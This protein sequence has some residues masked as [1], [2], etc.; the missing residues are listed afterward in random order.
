VG[1]LDDKGPGHPH[2]H[3]QD[4]TKGTT[5][6]PIQRGDSDSPS[7]LACLRL[8]TD[9]PNAGKHRASLLATLL[10]IAFGAPGVIIV[11]ARS[12]HHCAVRT[13]QANPPSKQ[14]SKQAS[15]AGGL[16]AVESFT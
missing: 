2:T 12:S 7:L 14:A 6:G 4:R 16:S 3:R 8:R 10:P 9:E 11:D 13:A 15:N 1:V 5:S